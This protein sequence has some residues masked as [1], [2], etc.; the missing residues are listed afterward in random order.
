M[1]LMF[2]RAHGKRRQNLLSVK[3]S[4]ANC[5]ISALFMLQDGKAA[6]LSC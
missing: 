5:A 6:W 2:L 4:G 1:Q 3:S